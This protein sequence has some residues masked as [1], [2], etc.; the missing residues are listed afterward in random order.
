MQMVMSR[1]WST[2]TMAIVAMRMWRKRQIRRCRSQ[3]CRRMKVGRLGQIP[4]LLSRF[5]P[6]RW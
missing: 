5:R 1:R 2:L 6:R 4:R 3:R